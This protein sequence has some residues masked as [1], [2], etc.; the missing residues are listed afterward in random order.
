MRWLLGAAFLLA[1]SPAFADERVPSRDLLFPPFAVSGIEL[2]NFD[3]ADARAE[4]REQSTS[5]LDVEPHSLFNIK[6]HIGVSA[7][8]DNGNARSG[9]GLYL[10][11]AEWGRWNFG[12]PGV[13]FGFGRYAVYDR[14]RRQSTMKNQSTLLVSLASVHYRVGYL[15][16]FGV[17]WYINLEQVYDMRTNLAGSQFGV[18][19]SR[20]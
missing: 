19:F 14:Q 13:E 15:R 8:Y 20:K 10:T 17:H 4:Q 12:L 1:V 5:R 16:S 7:G 3:L 2:V 6:R 9:V 11:V 18:S